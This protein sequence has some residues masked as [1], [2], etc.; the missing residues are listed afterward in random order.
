MS[1]SASKN[2]MNSTMG[3]NISWRKIPIRLK[4]RR[5]NEEGV[6]SAKIYSFLKQWFSFYENK[7]L[8]LMSAWTSL[9]RFGGKTLFSSN[10]DHADTVLKTNRLYDKS[11]NG[12]RFLQYAHNPLLIINRS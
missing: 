1:I 3:L 4:Y 6:S 2:V 10:E 11:Q 7:I 12:K 5:P 9:E 8:Q